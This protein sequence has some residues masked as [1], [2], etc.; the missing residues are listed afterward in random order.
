M[1]SSRGLAPALTPMM[2]V[3]SWAVGAILLMLITASVAT[4]AVSTWRT[5]NLLLAAVACGWMV[6]MAGIGWFVGWWLPYF[7]SLP[8]MLVAGWLINVTLAADTDGWSAVFS[9]IDDGIFT[10][11]I[12]PNSPVLGAQFIVFILVGIFACA[13]VRVRSLRLFE[14]A[15]G[16][17]MV[18]TSIAVAAS[19]LQS[20]PARRIAVRDAVGPRICTVLTATEAAV[21]AWP[22]DTAAQ[23]VAAQQ[24]AAMWE[25]LRAVG[26][27]SP[28]GVVDEGLAAPPNWVTATLWSSDRQDIADNLSLA[29]VVWLWC[30]ARSNRA[31]AGEELY[32]R[33]LWLQTKVERIDAG[34]YTAELDR[35]LKMSPDNQVQWLITRPPQVRCSSR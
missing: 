26:A 2:A 28:D 34:Y 29:T 1:G 30:G 8:L 25:P 14:G 16:L 21:C 24:A 3:A 11:S 13:M 10:A 12:V 27:R 31:D 18:I 20:G 33:Q 7:I 6:G 9:G 5:P 23:H 22:D 35:V 15:V 4:A 32:A 19:L 17:V